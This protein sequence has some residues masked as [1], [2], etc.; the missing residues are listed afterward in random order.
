MRKNDIYV[1]R[2][3]MYRTDINANIA[4]FLCLWTLIQVQLLCATSSFSVQ[5]ASSYAFTSDF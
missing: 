1:I 4:N 3:P 5:K 2:A